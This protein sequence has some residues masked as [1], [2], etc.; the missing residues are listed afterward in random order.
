MLH[1]HA[2]VYNYK[3]LHDFLLNLDAQPCYV[4]VWTRLV[5]RCT[6]NLWICL[7]CFIF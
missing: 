5:M 1:K 2:D 3:T 4:I 6:P 7:L